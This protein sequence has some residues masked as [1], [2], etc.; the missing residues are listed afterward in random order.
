[1]RSSVR[2]IRA[3]DLQ[4]GD[5]ELLDP[6]VKQHSNTVGSTPEHSGNFNPDSECGNEKNP[7]STP[8]ATPTLSP[9]SNR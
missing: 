2:I 4:V 7:L 6:F 3:K 1:M 8:E 5:R 9:Y